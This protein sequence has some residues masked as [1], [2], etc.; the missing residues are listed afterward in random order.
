VSAWSGG[1]LQRVALGALGEHTDERARDALAHAT[2]TLRP[3]TA[4]WEGSAG[5]V[6]AHRVTIG[7]DAR[8]LGTLRAAPAL[9][10]ALCAAVANAIATRPHES[11]AD[12][13]LRWDPGAQ[14]TV[15]EGYRGSPPGPEATLGEAL[16]DYLG[17]SGEPE[18]GRVVL[19]AERVA[20]GRGVLVRVDRASDDAR[21]RGILTRAVRDLL[22]DEGVQ[23]R[24]RT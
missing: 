12:V 4:G 1:E 7:L 24:I 19:T 23:L 9:A 17:A 13:E 22:A 20:G 8:R 11:L 21:S 5:H 2:L 18:L 15:L 3:A 16:A 14:A 10:D 6:E